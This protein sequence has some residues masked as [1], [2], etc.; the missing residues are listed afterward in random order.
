MIRLDHKRSSALWSVFF[1]LRRLLVVAAFIYV[2]E[3]VTFQIFIIIY[4]SLAAIVLLGLVQPLKTKRENSIE[5]FNNFLAIII[6]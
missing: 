2:Q 3:Y 5:M 6:Y 4:S 1:F